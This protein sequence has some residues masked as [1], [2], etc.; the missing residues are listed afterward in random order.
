MKKTILL[1]SVFQLSIFNFQFSTAQ[2]LKYYRYDTDLLSKE[3]H[4]GRRAALRD[5]MPG[6]SIAVLFANPERNRANDVDYEYHQD[7]NFYYLTGF[8]EPN[9]V[10]VIYKDAVIL[11]GNKVNEILY[12]PERDKADEIWNGRRAGTEGA[13]II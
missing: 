12:V 10:L 5:K 2:S 13:K 7:P 9:S 11:N 8:N 4:K 1:V 3:F 6:N